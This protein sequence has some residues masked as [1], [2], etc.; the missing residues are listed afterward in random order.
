MSCSDNHIRINSSIKINME[1]Q[2]PI[3]VKR[4]YVVQ[5]TQVIASAAAF[6][7]DS[8]IRG[9]V[10][11]PGP[12]VGKNLYCP[13]SG[14]PHQAARQ[15]HVRHIRMLRRIYLRRNRQPCKVAAQFNVISVKIFME[16]SKAAYFKYKGLTEI[17]AG[18]YAV[19]V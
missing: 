4:I 18:R 13:C 11:P 16:I 5:I 14:V 10:M 9:E 3:A 15:V 8:D 12:A 6:I 7:S 17:R 2:F 19:R 1:Y